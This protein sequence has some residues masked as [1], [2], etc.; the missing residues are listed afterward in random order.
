[1]SG[2]VIFY[3]Q[4]TETFVLP[5]WIIK[6]NSIMLSL[7]RS[8]ISGSHPRNPTILNDNHVIYFKG[9]IGIF[10]LACLS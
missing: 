9:T 1:M 6:S 8:H 3:I 5:Y 4:K 10:V 2:L 7:I